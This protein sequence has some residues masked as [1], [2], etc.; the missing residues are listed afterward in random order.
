[1]EMI[2][3]EMEKFMIADKLAPAEHGMA[4]AAWLGLHGKFH[5]RA[6]LAAGFGVDL[7]ITG[8][9]HDA[10]FFDASSSSFT[11]DNFQSRS[12]CP[13]TI[14]QHLQGQVALMGI[15]CGDKGV[16]D[17]HSLDAGD[18]WERTDSTQLVLRFTN[19]STLHTAR[20]Q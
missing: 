5:A 4:I 17:A 15:R 13:F 7:F 6:K 8:A 1:M 20:W 10:K 9:D 19:N 12:F 16:L 11:E 18:I 3:D 14:D 2:A